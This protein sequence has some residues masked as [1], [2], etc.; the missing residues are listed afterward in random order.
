VTSG[1]TVGPSVIAEMVRLAAFEVPGVQAV[2]RSGPMWRRALLGPA[3]EVHVD[4]NRVSIGVALVARPGQPLLPLVGQVRSAVSS[5]VERLLGM[6]L[7]AVSVVVDG[8][9]G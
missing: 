1:L 9:G 4:G 3:V 2:G 6:E 8:V 7:E 5:A